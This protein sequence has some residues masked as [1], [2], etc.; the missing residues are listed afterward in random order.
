MTLHDSV[1][2]RLIALEALMREHHHWQ[3]SMPDDSAFASTQ[4]FCMDTLEPLQWL[5][6]VL[7][8]RMRQMIDAGLPLPQTFAVAPYYE[9]ALEATH[10][11]RDTLL[12][13][14]QQLD[15]L[16]TEDNV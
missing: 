15:A 10:P 6:W 4:P 2:A 16:F 3:E 7:I 14:L 8:P 5:Q 1:R 9:M 11:F 12:P 13:E